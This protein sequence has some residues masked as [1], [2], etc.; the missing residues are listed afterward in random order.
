MTNH[1]RDEVV[2][3]QDCNKWDCGI[4]SL[5]SNNLRL[6]RQV[7]EGNERDDRRALQKLDGIIS[8]GGSI[9][10]SAWGRIMYLNR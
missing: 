7:G 9:V 1:Q 3:N 10:T 8:E 4:A 6:K 5:R 2:E